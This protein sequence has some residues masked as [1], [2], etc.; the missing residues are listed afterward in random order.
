MKTPHSC[1]NRARRRRGGGRRGAGTAAGDAARLGI[2]PRWLLRDPRPH[3][4]TNLPGLRLLLLSRACADPAWW[5]LC[6]WLG[7]CS[8]AGTYGCPPLPQPHSG[9]QATEGRSCLVP[10][11]LCC[12]GDVDLFPPGCPVCPLPRVHRKYTSSLDVI[13][14]L[15]TFPFLKQ[16]KLQEQKTEQWLPGVEGGEKGVP[17][18]EF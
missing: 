9:V 4:S 16:E 18:K 5:C 13:Y 7:T 3:R 6:C 11:G 8:A 10:L 1:S 12:V 2:S 14:P 17:C 15:T